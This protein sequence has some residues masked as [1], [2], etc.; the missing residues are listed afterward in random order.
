MQYLPAP[1]KKNHACRPPGCY[2]ALLFA[3]FTLTC[4]VEQDPPDNLDI[5]QLE[6]DSYKLMIS[7]FSLILRNDI[8]WSR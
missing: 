2:E 6:K 7:R 1:P 5:F 8:R 3:D 4:H